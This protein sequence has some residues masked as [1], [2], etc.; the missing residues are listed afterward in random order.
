MV[1]PSWKAIFRLFGFFKSPIT[2]QVWEDDFSEHA[3]YTEEKRR[4][5]RLAQIARERDALKEQLAKAIRDKK[6]RAPIYQALRAL[7]V[8]ELRVETGK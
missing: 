4:N 8:E 5:E 2:P 6:A 3:F 7:S 1:C